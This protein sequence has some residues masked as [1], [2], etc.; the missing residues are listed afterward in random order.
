MM[1]THRPTNPFIPSA[2]HFAHIL[3]ICLVLHVTMC[4][5]TYWYCKIN[6]RQEPW[7]AWPGIARYTEF[8]SIFT[9]A[10]KN[11]IFLTTCIFCTPYIYIVC[12]R[13]ASCSAAYAIKFSLFCI[14]CTITICKCMRCAY[15]IATQWIDG[16]SLFSVTKIIR[17]IVDI[18]IL[19]AIV[20][21][22]IYVCVFVITIKLVFNPTKCIKC[23][24]DVR[25]LSICPECGLLCERSSTTR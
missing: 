15:T 12:R 7:V 16:V 22:V 14:L 6:P 23:R 4:I 10:A 13:R 20:F 2:V 3:V 11:Y 1:I 8:T 18:N 24:Y 25:G 17:K 9:S 19:A 5:S 21:F